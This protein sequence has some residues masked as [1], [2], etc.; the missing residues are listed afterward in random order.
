MKS[1]PKRFQCRAFYPGK[2]KGLSG[3]RSEDVV[4]FQNLIEA[5]HAEAALNRFCQMLP[6][7]GGSGWR[8]EDDFD[9]EIREV[10]SC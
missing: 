1:E 5:P 8:I 4:I 10:K 6:A 2:T 3:S 9:V 7:A